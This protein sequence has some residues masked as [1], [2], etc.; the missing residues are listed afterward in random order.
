PLSLRDISPARG[1]IGGGGSAAN[2]ADISTGS[3]L[4]IV[5]TA[6]AG[7]SPFRLRSFEFERTLKRRRPHL[8]RPSRLPLSLL[9]TF[10]GHQSV[11]LIMLLSCRFD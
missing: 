4:E 10:S 5:K 11:H 8:Q 2:N 6:D 3:I 9:Q 7:L 1:E